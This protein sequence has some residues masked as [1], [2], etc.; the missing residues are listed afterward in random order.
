MKSR[1]FKASIQIAAV[2]LLLF[3]VAGLS[4]L[5]KNSQYFPK[6]NPTHFVNIASKM[7]VAPTP[8]VIERVPLY[9]FAMVVSPQPC[10]SRNYGVDEISLPSPSI[11][12]TVS[13]QPRSPPTSRS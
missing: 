2:V 3:A 7:K 9:P 10:P 1:S 13:I 6:S 5:A 12:I 4:T 11:G 8:V